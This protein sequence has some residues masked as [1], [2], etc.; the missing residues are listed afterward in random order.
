MFS[1][2]FS[3]N[4]FGYFLIDVNGIPFLFLGVFMEFK[5]LAKFKSIAWL[6]TLER[7]ILTAVEVLKNQ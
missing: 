6:M 2:T 1:D 4:S 5:C 7:Y 3:M